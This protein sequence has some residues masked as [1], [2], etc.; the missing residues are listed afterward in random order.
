VHGL[1]TELGQD[2]IAVYDPATYRGRLVGP[3]AAAWGLFDPSC[4]I[5]P[6][7]EWLA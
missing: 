7:G 4:F 5:L 1:C 2:C 6:S 3:N